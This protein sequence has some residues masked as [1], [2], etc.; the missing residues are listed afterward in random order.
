[1]TVSLEV[2]H[3]GPWINTLQFDALLGKKL[4]GSVLGFMIVN[5]MISHHSRTAYALD[6]MLTFN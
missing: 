6:G 1:M 5:G 3:K 2:S 4:T